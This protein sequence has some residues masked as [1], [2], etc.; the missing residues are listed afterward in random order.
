LH[1]EAIR[2]SLKGLLL[3]LANLT[4]L[5]SSQ[6]PWIEAGKIIPCQL[7]LFAQSTNRC[8]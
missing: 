8:P 4:S 6:R 1:A 5:D 3:W 7:P 2:N